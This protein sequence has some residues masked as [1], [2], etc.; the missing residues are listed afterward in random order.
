M[1]RFF[2]PLAWV[3]KRKLMWIPFF[4]WGLGNDPAIVI[5][6][7]AVQ[8]ASQQLLESGSSR[9]KAGCVGSWF[10]RK[11]LTFYQGNKNVI[12]REARCWPAK[13]AYPLYRLPIT[14]ATPGRAGSS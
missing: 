14:A 6:R 13:P 1:S 9:L 2:P 12:S 7:G 10:S 8:R 3:V 4:G 11:E 5:N